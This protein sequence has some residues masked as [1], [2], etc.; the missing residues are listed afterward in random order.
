MLFIAGYFKLPEKTAEDFYNEGGKRWFRTGDIAEMF[1]DGTVRIVDRFTE[2][3]LLFHKYYW[4]G[5]R[6]W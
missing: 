1:E 5:R 6:T 4:T 3:H 2:F